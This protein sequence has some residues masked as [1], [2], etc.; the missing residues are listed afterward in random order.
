MKKMLIAFACLMACSLAFAANGPKNIGKLTAQSSPIQWEAVKNRPAL[1]AVPKN[2]NTLMVTVMN[3][4]DSL[5]SV[6]VIWEGRNL[7][8][9][10]PVKP[11][12]G[13]K[14]DIVEHNNHGQLQIITTGQHSEGTVS[15]K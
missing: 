4:K 2:D 7:T 6:N 15:I 10:N 3:N 8:M 5:A 1:F 9:K 11:G 13:L 14:F 12:S